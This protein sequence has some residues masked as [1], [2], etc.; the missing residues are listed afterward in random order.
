VIGKAAT[1]TRKT[2]CAS[3]KG[4]DIASPVGKGRDRRKKEQSP[5]QERHTFNDKI[6]AI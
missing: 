3:P 6:R 4:R 1:E 2:G 5:F